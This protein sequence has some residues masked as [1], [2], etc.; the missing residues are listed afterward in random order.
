MTKR[1]LFRFLGYAFSVIPPVLAI[2]EYFPLFAKTGGQ[3][4]LSGIAFLLLLLAAIPLR[5]GI[6]GLVRR[7]L[8]SPSAPGVWAVLWIFCAWFGRIAE[9]IAA[10]ALVGALSS[11][12]GMLFFHLG[13]K[14]ERDGG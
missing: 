8:D 13:G 7:Y 6:T 5:R 9:A 11:L 12:L 4:I 14:G 1:I 10:V 3:P 2:L